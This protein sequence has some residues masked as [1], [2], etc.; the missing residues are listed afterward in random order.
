MWWNNHVKA[1]VKRKEGAGSLEIKIPWKGFWK[2]TER[3]REQL[4]G[5]LIKVR[6]R[7]KNNLEGRLIKM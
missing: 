5:R 4:K 7:S 2:S 6:R 3:K 1:A